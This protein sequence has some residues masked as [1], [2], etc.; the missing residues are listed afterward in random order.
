MVRPSFADR[1]QVQSARVVLRVRPDQ[2]RRWEAKA[3]QYGNGVSLSEWI[4]TTLD[5]AARM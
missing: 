2:R 3:K 4:R 5:R 1:T